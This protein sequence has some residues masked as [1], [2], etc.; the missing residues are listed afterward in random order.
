MTYT[1]PP[2][3]APA[4]FTLHTLSPGIE[5]TRMGVAFTS[6]VSAV[7]PTA[8][9]AMFLPF[10]LET[11]ATCYQLFCHN[12]ATVS[13]NVDMGIYDSGGTRKVS[14]G[15]TVQAGVSTLQLF[16][17]ADTALDPGL[18]YL[19]LAL[20]NISATILRFATVVAQTHCM[21]MGQRFADTA[22]PLPAS[23]TYV[24]DT[25]ITGHL[26]YFGGQFRSTAV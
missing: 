6:F 14:I 20:D 19:A 1:A 3:P 22:F 9:R 23:V 13:G 21:E 26:P 2:R 4:L 7:W 10:T 11:P 8:N 16:D 18:W 17:I 5:H 25:S 15:S 24:E 12:G